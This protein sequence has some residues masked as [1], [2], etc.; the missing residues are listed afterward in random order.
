MRRDDFETWLVNRRR[1]NEEPFREDTPNEHARKVDRVEQHYDVDFDTLERE[2]IEN[3]YKDFNYTVTDENNGILPPQH[4]VDFGLNTSNSVR[5]YRNSMLN[6][7]TFC[8][9]R[10]L[11]LD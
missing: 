3:F 1:E 11:D 5:G 7:F 9:Y 10:N 4:L 8:G 6:Y 2:Y